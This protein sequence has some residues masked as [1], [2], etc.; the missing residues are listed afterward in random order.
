MV[1][2]ITITWA[3]SSINIITITIV[4]YEYY[5]Y[6]KNDKNSKSIVKLQVEVVMN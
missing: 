6:R 4:T 3:E 5:N 1:L 2:L